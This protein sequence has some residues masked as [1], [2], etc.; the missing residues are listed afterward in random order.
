MLFSDCGLQ[1]RF[2]SFQIISS[3]LSELKI[4]S[5]SGI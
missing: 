1:L 2:F 5:F 4:L 3:F